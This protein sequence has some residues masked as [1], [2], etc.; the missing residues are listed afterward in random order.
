MVDIARE[1]PW[2]AP[3]I[4]IPV[5]NPLHAPAVRR[6]AIEAMFGPEVLDY[7]D[8]NYPYIRSHFWETR[9]GRRSVYNYAIP[10]EDVLDNDNDG[11][12][13]FLSYVTQVA[14]RSVYPCAINLSVSSLLRTNP[15]ER[16]TANLGYVFGTPARV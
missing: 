8:Y 3:G 11:S 14:A 16:K 4:E 5:D 13:L 7:Y 1:A 15:S 10:L 9:R 12:E 2:F 6:Q